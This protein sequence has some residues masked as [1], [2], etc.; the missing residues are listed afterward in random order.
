MPS[1]KAASSSKNDEGAAITA[2]GRALGAI[3]DQGARNRVLQWAASAYGSG[4]SLQLG[5][6]SSDTSGGVAGG[7]GTSTTQSSVA[8][9]A[10]AKAF[11]AQKRPT[12]DVYKALCLAYWLLHKKST[13]TFKAKDLTDLARGDAATPFGHAAMAVS[14]AGRSGFFAPAGGGRKQLTPKGEGIVEALPDAA[15]VKEVLLTFPGRKR[16]KPKKKK[17][18]AS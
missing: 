3:E 6:G 14:N 12:S 13:T 4:A 2:I 8:S 15:K 7:T 9:A 10:N 11:M 1:K 17:K 18:A 5:G 16:A